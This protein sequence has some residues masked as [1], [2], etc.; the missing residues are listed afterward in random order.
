MP[1]SQHN[2]YKCIPA[3]LQPLTRYKE[4]IPHIGEAFANALMEIIP[5]Y[6]TSEF[7]QEMHQLPYKH[8][9]FRQV[10]L[11]RLSYQD[12]YLVG[13][14]DKSKAKSAYASYCAGYEIKSPL[15]AYEFLVFANQHGNSLSIIHHHGIRQYDALWLGHAIATDVREALY[16]NICKLAQQ[17]LWIDTDALAYSPQTKDFKVLDFQKV[18]LKQQVDPVMKDAYLSRYRKLLKI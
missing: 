9:E 3:P 4:L 13:Y 18:S 12:E 7:L 1:E 11:G 5:I 15:I 17:S 10:S 8:K 2:L 16:E 14:M 6:N